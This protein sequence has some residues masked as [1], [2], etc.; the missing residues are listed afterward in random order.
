[1]QIRGCRGGGRSARGRPDAA[2][3]RRRAR[4]SASSPEHVIA[5]LSR[6]QHVPSCTWVI[7]D[8]FDLRAEP[9]GRSSASPRA[10]PVFCPRPSARGREVDLCRALE[11][12]LY[13]DL[14]DQREVPE[15][16]A[17][18][19]RSAA[20]RG[21]GAG[22]A[23]PRRDR[24]G[25][26]SSPTSPYGCSRRSR[27]PESPLRP[28]RVR[29]RASV[30]RGGANLLPGRVILE[31]LDLLAPSRSEATSIS[32]VHCAPGHAARNLLG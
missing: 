22:T 11:P 29:A 5:L 21:L 13:V 17:K 8:V 1:M 27:A 32:T 2:D 4:S 10:A 14:A 30:R 18:R 26:T 31:H 23:G 20:S 12:L 25:P 19:S 7:Y 15:L 3:G 16:H 6:G 28:Y 24:R 9:L